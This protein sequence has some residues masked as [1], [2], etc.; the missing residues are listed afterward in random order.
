MTSYRPQQCG[1]RCVP[2]VISVFSWRVVDGGMKSSTMIH[3]RASTRYMTKQAKPSGTNGLGQW[4]TTCATPHFCVGHVLT[5]MD[6]EDATQAGT[7]GQ[8]H[9]PRLTLPLSLSRSLLRTKRQAGHIQRKGEAWW[10]RIYWSTS[11]CNPAVSCSSAR[12]LS[13]LCHIPY[14]IYN[15]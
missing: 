15:I 4:W 3:F 5:V 1:S 8:R 12:L 7:I 13:V 10:T 11:C 9:P 6:S 2:G 14:I